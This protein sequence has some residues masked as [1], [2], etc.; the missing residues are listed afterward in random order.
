MPICMSGHAYAH[1]L[2]VVY[3][4]KPSWPAGQLRD[5]IDDVLERTGMSQVQLAAIVPMD[6]GQIS[7]W[8]SGSSKPK[9]ETL[10]ALGSALRAKFPDL[11]IGPKEVREAVYPA[12]DAEPIPPGVQY[13]ID[14]REL[15]RQVMREELERF[16]GEI[17]EEI[18]SE[19]DDRDKRDKAS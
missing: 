4:V 10:A 5:L 2:M 1:R 9:P 14:Q 6:Q 17:T 3:M 13:A 15:I 16:R 12:D 18:R 11:G 8:R 19:L 7:R